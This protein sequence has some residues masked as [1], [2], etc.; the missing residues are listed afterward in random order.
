MIRHTI[1][2]LLGLTLMVIASGCAVGAPDDEIS[3]E[4]GEQ[5]AEVSEALVLETTYDQCSG[6]LAVYNINHSLV[7]VPRGAWKTIAVEPEFNWK[8]GSSFESAT[9]EDGT[10]YVQVYHSTSSRQITWLCSF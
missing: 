7:P 6:N 8:C 4:S 10:T 3:A 1:S 2:A 5:K 9:C